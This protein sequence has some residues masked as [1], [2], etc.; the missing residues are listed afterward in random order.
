MEVRA[1][2]PMVGPS[3]CYEGP[4]VI[5]PEKNNLMNLHVQ[6]SETLEELF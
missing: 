1:K 4:R 6:V 5:E 3:V 2:L